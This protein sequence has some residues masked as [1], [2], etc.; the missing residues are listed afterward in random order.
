MKTAYSQ[1][2]EI[3]PK[4]LSSF[5]RTVE[6]INHVF[7]RFRPSFLEEWPRFW[8][9]G[10]AIRDILIRE[11]VSD[12]DVFF[13]TQA[14]F[15]RFKAVLFDQEDFEVI[16]ETGNAIKARM[17]KYKVDLVKA[18]NPSPQA[19]L[20]RFDFTVTMFAC[21]GVKIYTSVEALTDL[22]GKRLV[23][24]NP[25][26]PVATMRRLAKYVAKGY[27]P[28]AGTMLVLG[29]AVNGLTTEEFLADQTFYLD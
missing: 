27:R 25:T 28:C 7:E 12:Y 3:D 24:N 21:D 14:D 17:G 22:A 5:E 6:H 8:V 1:I 15:D 20:A 26:H 23:I 13:P 9:A 18:F 19:T 29:Q 10:G 16:M 11:K 4:P 2:L